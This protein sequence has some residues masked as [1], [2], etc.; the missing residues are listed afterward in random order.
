MGMSGISL[1]LHLPVAKDVGR[2]RGALC[3]V[4]VASLES[5][6]KSFAHFSVGLSAFFLLICSGFFFIL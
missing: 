5:V 1:N 3:H 4:F 2:G 6:C